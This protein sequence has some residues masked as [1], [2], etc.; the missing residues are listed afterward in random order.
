MLPASLS[1]GMTT[2]TRIKCPLS[3]RQAAT[4]LKYSLSVAMHTRL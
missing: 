4:P 1:A 3:L 2:V